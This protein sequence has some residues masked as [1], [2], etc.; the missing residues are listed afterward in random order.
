MSE[1]RCHPKVKL[2][3]G[4]ITNNDTVYEKTK[5]ILIRYFGNTDFESA[6]FD[7]NYT[8]YYEEEMGK[9]LKRR[10]LG[11]KKLIPPERIAKIKVMTNKI[12]KRFSVKGKRQINIDPGY[13][14]LSKLVLATTKDYK[15]RIYLGK[16][17]FG[18][19]TLFFTND[20]F[21]GWDC[22]YPD[23][24][25]QDYINTFNAIRG[26]YQKQTSEAQTYGAKRT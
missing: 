14:N 11:F 12:E 3:A 8:K 5:K 10:F 13:V 7:F 21:Q 16:G 1:I 2:V 23:Y 24:R 19:I 18:E 22:T 17:I 15:H 6:A 9:G 26:L 25:A 4:I 20:T